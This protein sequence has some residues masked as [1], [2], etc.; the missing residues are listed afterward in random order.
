MTGKLVADQLIKTAE[1]SIA[2][3]E[4][5]GANSAVRLKLVHLSN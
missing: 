5:R 1:K 4:C 2:L 3:A